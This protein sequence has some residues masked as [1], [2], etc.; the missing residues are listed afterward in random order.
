MAAHGCHVSTAQY[1]KPI[2]FSGRPNRPHALPHHPL[3][4]RPAQEPGAAANGND[5]QNP[6]QS[7][8]DDPQQQQLPPGYS[9]YLHAHIRSVREPRRGQHALVA[10]SPEDDPA[11][12]AGALSGLKQALSGQAAEY[13]AQ[14]IK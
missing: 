14:Q 2:T 7:S 11:A 10:P 3:N 1:L 9:R 8:I 5:A 13:V 4:T 6:A 12:Y